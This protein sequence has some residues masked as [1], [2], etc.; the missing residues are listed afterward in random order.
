MQT[1]A[2]LSKLEQ[3]YWRLTGGLPANLEQGFGKSAANLGHLQQICGKSG[4][5][6]RH[7][8]GKSGANPGKIGG[9]S[10]AI[11]GQVWCKSG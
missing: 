4:A 10:G 7:I 9:K 8:C 6:L 2:T 5:N 3:T 11:L 1:S